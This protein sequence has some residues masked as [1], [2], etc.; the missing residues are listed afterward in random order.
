MRTIEQIMSGLTVIL[1][2]NKDPINIEMPIDTQ[3]IGYLFQ[4]VSYTWFISVSFIFALI[5][6]IVCLILIFM[7]IYKARKTQETTQGGP[8]W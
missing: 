6:F 4:H 1:L 2:I 5:M 3:N 7:M 8:P